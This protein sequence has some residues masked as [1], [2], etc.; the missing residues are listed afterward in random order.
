MCAKIDTKNYD[1]TKLKENSKQFEKILKICFICGIAIV[2]SFIIYYLLS[3]EPGYVGFGILNSEKK[4]ENY[5]TEAH[6]N[7]K[8][9]FYITVE[10][11]FNNEFRFRLKIFVGDE[12]T[13]LSSAGSK[14]ARLVL[15]SAVI[16][17]ENNTKW[18]SPKLHVQFTKVGSNQPLIAE[19][20]E[21]TENNEENF[22]DILWLR[23]NIIS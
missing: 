22:Y 20:Y 12:K 23:L 17:L 16:T 19:L 13:E 15:S 10:N 3:P 6:V 14:G 7:E 21:I 8:I 1:K 4:A 5:P 9:E 18:I 2:S 11:H